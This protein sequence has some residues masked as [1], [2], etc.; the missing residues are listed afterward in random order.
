MNRFGIWLSQFCTFQVVLITLLVVF[1]I[2]SVGILFFD[3][4]ENWVSD[5]VGGTTKNK[6]LKFLG[7]GMGGILIVLLL[8][9][10]FTMSL[11]SKLWQFLIDNLDRILVG[12]LVFLVIISIGVMGSDYVKNCVSGLIGLTAKNKI[13]TFLGIGMGGILFIL[14]VLA[15]HRRAKAMEDASNAQA[16][17]AKAQARAN[18]NTEQGLRQE[19]LKNAIEHLGH[20]KDTVRLGGAYELFHLAEDSKDLRKTALDMLCLHIRQT[21]GEKEYQKKHESKP[22]EEVQSLLTLLFVQEHEVFKGLQINLRGSWLNGADLMGAR[23]EK[24]IL[25]EAH[26]KRANLYKA[27]LQGADLRTARLQ[28]ATLVEA[29]LQGAFLSQAHLQGASLRFAHLQGASLIEAHLQGVKLLEAH[30][31]EA[32]LWRIHLQGANLRGA[33]LQGAEL[34]SAYLQG[35]DL[36]GAR[37][38][39]ADLSRAHLQGAELGEARL[40]GSNLQ[41]THLQGTNLLG[42]YLQ[43][44][45]L[46][47]VRLQGAGNVNWSS[48]MSFGDRIHMQIHKES[49]PSGIIF[50]GGLTKEDVN[51]LVEGLSDEKV[52]DLRERL[53]SHI[54]IPESNEL[55]EGSNAITGAYTEEDAEKWIAEYEEAMLEVPEDDS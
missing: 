36:F 10:K 15:S 25:T 48:T 18:E 51:S 11:F 26:L 41:G 1:E 39:S 5:L 14:Q 19:R 46:Y 22:S 37:L 52:D 47:R 45:N 32:K 29:R 7:M 2:V 4:V 33:H 31:Q 20:G 16:D 6:I 9:W 13:L 30:L 49:D 21:T 43:G 53:E 55:P 44:S 38:Q 17:A 50:A 24:A 35:A 28:G 27:Q 54:G 8:S 40:Q 12:L 23:L 42:V 34:W 3:G